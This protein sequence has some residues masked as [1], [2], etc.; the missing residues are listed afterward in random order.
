MLELGHLEERI[1]ATREIPPREARYAPIPADCPE[2]LRGP[3]T[4]RLGVPGPARE[5]H[6]A[7]AGLPPRALLRAHV[8]QLHG[9][10][11]GSHA[12][13]ALRRAAGEPGLLVLVHCEPVATMRLA[14]CAIG[15]SISIATGEVRL[16]WITPLFNS[17][18]SAIVCW[19]ESI[20]SATSTRQPSVLERVSQP[21]NCCFM[22]AVLTNPSS[23]KV[24]SSSASRDVISIA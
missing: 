16:V 13:H 19:L 2:P 12:A 22:L 5:R 14:F 7:P 1:V 11:E 17:A 21:S 3:R 20:V 6:H 15:F 4:R 9:R 18:L 24:P 23:G 8:R 10:A